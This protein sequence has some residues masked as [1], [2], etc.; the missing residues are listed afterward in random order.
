MENLT[1]QP[2]KP[3]NHLVWAILTTVFCC[4]PLGIVSIVKS[5]KV[6]E[7]YAQG[8]Y[9]EAQKASNE[10]K[11]SAMWSAIVAG[12]LFLL[13][14]LLLILGVAGGILSDAGGF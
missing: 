10:A 7:L 13:Y 8:N 9:A 5:T 4:L 1:N 11:K 14:I 3:D 12:G 6:N 2:P